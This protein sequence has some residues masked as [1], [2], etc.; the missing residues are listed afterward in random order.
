MSSA[1]ARAEFFRSSWSLY[2]VVIRENY[3]FHREIQAVAG[4]VVMEY[5]GRGG[6]A[7][8]D[9]GCGS[10]RGLAAALRAVPP[11]LYVGVDLSRPA[12][13]DAA[14]ELS[15]LP[16]VRLHEWDM[17][18]CAEALEGRDDRFD[19]VYSGFAMHHFSATDKAR[20]FRAI[21][22]TLSPGGSF[23]LVDVVREPGQSREAYLEGYVG[24]VEATWTAL[25]RGQVGQVLEHVSACDFPET[26]ADLADMA[27]EAGLGA[28]RTLARHGQHHV[29]LF[30]RES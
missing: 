24:V 28:C 9:L 16:S 25:N 7:V 2:D 11:A 29:I 13:D 10:A 14:V 26:P 17:L 18:A 30:Q 6:Y 12:L 8:L 1:E 4:R 5:A 3:M 21:S 20:L 22:T 19:L 27:R 23:L 15:G